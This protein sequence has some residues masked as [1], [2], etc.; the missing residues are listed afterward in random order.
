MAYYPGEKGMDFEMV[1]VRF[2]FFAIKASA[3]GWEV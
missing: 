1:I 2:T 3:L